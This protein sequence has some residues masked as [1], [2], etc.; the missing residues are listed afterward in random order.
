L[1]VSRRKSSSRTARTV[2]TTRTT[3]RPASTRVDSLRKDG[4][5]CHVALG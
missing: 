4:G 1:T 2:E 3:K 5:H